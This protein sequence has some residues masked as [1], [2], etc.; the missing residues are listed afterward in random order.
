MRTP[1]FGPATPVKTSSGQTQGL[2][3]RLNSSEQE[4]QGL[5]A[6]PGLTHH[7]FLGFLGFSWNICYTNV[8][9]RE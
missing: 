6:R 8:I 7:S 5:Y 2:D 1:I 9:I 3:H 4:S